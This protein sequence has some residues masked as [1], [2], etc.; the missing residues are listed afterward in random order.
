MGHTKMNRTIYRDVRGLYFSG[1]GSDAQ[2]LIAMKSWGG[3]HKNMVGISHRAD[4]SHS[5]SA[6]N[7]YGGHTGR[8]GGGPRAGDWDCRLCENLNFAF[9][10]DRY[11]RCHTSKPGINRGGERESHCSNDARIPSPPLGTSNNAR[12]DAASDGDGEIDSGGHNEE[13]DKLKVAVS[14]PRAVQEIGGTSS[15]TPRRGSRWS[16]FVGLAGKGLGCVRILIEIAMPAVGRVL[17]NV[18]DSAP[19]YDKVFL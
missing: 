13:S 15:G 4:L 3:G 18:L 1:R 17:R 12:S 2:G 11:G 6:V 7:V 8:A 10:I 16:Q 19:K 14:G 9:R 5:G